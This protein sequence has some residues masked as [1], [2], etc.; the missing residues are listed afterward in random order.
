MAGNSTMYELLNI[1]KCG[2]EEVKELLST[3]DVFI[4][5]DQVVIPSKGKVGTFREKDYYNRFIYGDNI[6]VL[7]ALVKGDG[8]ES[9]RGKIDLI[10]IDPP[11]LS[12]AD[13]KAKV[14]LPLRDDTVTIEVFAYSDTWKDGNISYL[15]MLYPRLVLMRELLSERG[16]IY[17]HLDWRMVHYVKILMDEIF[18]EDMFLNEII[19]SYKSGGVSKKYFSRKH[20]TILLYSKTKNYIFNPQKEKSYNRGFKPYRFK[21]VKEYEDE[22]GWHTLVNMKDV[23]NVDMVGR[24][25]KERVGYDTQKPEKLLERMILSS[26]EEGSIVADFFGG[27]GTTAVVAEKHNRKWILS[28][29][30]TT[31][32]L[33]IMKRL[34][35]MNACEFLTQKIESAVFPKLGSLKIGKLEKLKERNGEE[36]INIEFKGYDIEVSKIPIVEKYKDIVVEVMKENSL[37]LIDTISIDTD[38]DGKCF[39]SRWQDYR[40]LENLMINDSIQLKVEERDN[41][42]IC[43]RV[44][45]VFGY[46]SE[47]ILEV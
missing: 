23:W 31:S 35:D 21:G 41:R 38:Y 6:D 8:C 20:D 7:G 14:K 40:K 32:H 27:S 34:I 45:D 19:W 3:R 13:Y 9:M 17:V 15:E 47:Y 24:T 33:T 2:N 11:F 36:I 25:S 29:L 12:K 43:I 16:S 39:F 30:G 4:K 22:I 46:H 37:A 10:Y 26:T 1:V 28:D 5:T 44:V 42:T 18:G